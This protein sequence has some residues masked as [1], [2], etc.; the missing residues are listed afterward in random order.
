MK[1]LEPSVARLND[2]LRTE[3]GVTEAGFPKYQWRFCGD[4]IDVFALH[5]KD[6]SKVTD[7]VFDANSG[8]YL[9][10]TRTIRKLQSEKHA[11][12]WAICYWEAPVSEKQ[13]LNS[14]G[15]LEDYPA[16]GT[17]M[18]C[19]GCIHAEGVPPTRKTT[20]Q[21]IAEIRKRRMKTVKEHVAEDI[22]ADKRADQKAEAELEEF[23]LDKVPA[24]LN[25]QPGA[26]GGHVSFGGV[27]KE[28]TNGA[29]CVPAA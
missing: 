5:H 10:K 20:Q 17:Y 24:F 14:F 8:L 9:A 12:Q 23:F 26:R 18:I 13:W 19:Q 7:H 4:L 6:G 28:K 3:L 22:A 2:L 29:T 21:F 25:V 27:E 11:K 15:T 16:G 1:H